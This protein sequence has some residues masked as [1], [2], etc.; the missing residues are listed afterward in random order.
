MWNW[1]KSLFKTKEQNC[2][3]SLPIDTKS[4]SC[5]DKDNVGEIMISTDG[6]LDIG[7]GEGFTID[8]LDGSLGG[9]VGGISIDLF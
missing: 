5:E 4:T 9:D 7:I 1:I 8:P 2:N 6:N 3:H